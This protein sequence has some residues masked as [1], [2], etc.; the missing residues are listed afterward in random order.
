M[1]DAD[2]FLGLAGI[3]GVFVGFGALIAV[4]SGGPTEPQEVT[5]VR[6]IVSM[7]MLAVLAALD[8]VT[9]ARFDLTEHQV[10]GLSSALMLLGW[11]AIMLALVRTPEYKPNAVAM[12]EADR[13]RPR[14]L[15]VIEGVVWGLYVLAALI[16]PV[17]IILGLV[18]EL[19]AALY[20]AA[21]V[22]ILLGAGWFLLVLVFAQRPPMTA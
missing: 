4:R 17:V 7:G 19:E 10:W 11:F 5:P 9:L 12:L 16:T 15:V 18:P 6:G 22:L 1:Q 13:A 14:W 20:F 21:V 3:A 8:P 2:L